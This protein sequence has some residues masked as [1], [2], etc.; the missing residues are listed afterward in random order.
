MMIITKTIDMLERILK[1]LLIVSSVLL[2]LACSPLKPL[3]PKSETVYTLAPVSSLQRADSISR[4]KATAKQNKTTLLV[5]IPKVHSEYRGNAMVYSSKPY[6]VEKFSKH[7]WIDQPA[8]ML[9]PLLVQVMQNVPEFNSVMASPFSG[10][11]DYR[12]DTEIIDFKQDFSQSQSQFKLTLQASLID[13]TSQ[14][15]IASKQFS[16]TQ[17]T[18]ANNPKSGVTAANQAVMA[19]MNELESFVEGE[20]KDI[21]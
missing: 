7:R 9:Q 11:S 18:K 15:V 4:T 12:L 2:C 17:A 5:S 16:R 1:L 13:S 3:P 14:R 6:Q 19:L 21:S 10:R 8:K 20:F